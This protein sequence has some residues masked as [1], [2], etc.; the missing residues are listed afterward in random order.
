MRPPGRFFRFPPQYLVEDDVET[1]T[2]LSIEQRTRRDR[3]GE[4]LFQA[5]RLGAKL[6]LIAIVCLGLAPLV[7]HGKGQP[8]TV[9]PAV[10]L[11][12]VGLPDQPKTKRPQRHTIF[13][14]HITPRFP[15]LVMHSLVHDPAF[16]GAPALRPCLLNMD[17]RALA[18]AEHQMLQGGK[19]NQIFWTVH[20]VTCYLIYCLYLLLLPD[21][22]FS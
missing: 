16:G 5:D 13:D 22:L 14:P 1:V 18:G 3:D 21:S 11:H 9:R 15:A 17:E 10:K 20:V 6:N 2:C 4:H 19:L 8:G 7:L 12:D